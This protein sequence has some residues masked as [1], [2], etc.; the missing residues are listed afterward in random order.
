MASPKPLTAIERVRRK[1][2]R[3]MIRES[4]EAAR[5]YQLQCRLQTARLLDDLAGVA[6]LYLKGAK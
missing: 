4:R 1:K 5:N 2:I 3:A 6:E